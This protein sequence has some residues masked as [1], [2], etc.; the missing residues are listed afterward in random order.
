MSLKVIQVHFSWDPFSASR[1]FCS[2]GAIVYI[3]FMTRLF[4]VWHTE[5]KSYPIF[6]GL[7]TCRGVEFVD[8]VSLGNGEHV[9]RIFIKLYSKLSPFTSSQWYWLN[10]VSYCDKHS[11]RMAQDELGAKDDEE[12]LPTQWNI[13]LLLFP[14]QFNVH[15]SSGSRGFVLGRR[16]NWGVVRRDFL[17]RDHI[18][19]HKSLKY[20]EQNT[21]HAPYD[22]GYETETFFTLHT[23]SAFHL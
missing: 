22:K 1:S 18:T 10:C 5:E 16:L 14:Q 12:A 8:F 15:M 17:P 11:M 19:S 2:E 6:S 21:P 23:T 13:S 3:D 4:W 9:R 20:R 7:K